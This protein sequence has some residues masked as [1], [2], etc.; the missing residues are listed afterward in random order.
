MVKNPPASA[1]DTRNVGLIPGL[2]RALGEEMATLSSIC[3]WEIP[4]TEGPGGLQ[5]TV[6]GVQE[7]D[8]T[9]HGHAA[10]TV[11]IL[12]INALVLHVGDTFSRSITSP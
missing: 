5:S 8:V 7:S 1:G 11:C 4:S 12:N 9:E 6:H 3:A 10:T 2:R